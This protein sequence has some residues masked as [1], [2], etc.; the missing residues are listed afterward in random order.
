MKVE[1]GFGAK[2]VQPTA[3]VDVDLNVVFK[4]VADILTERAGLTIDAEKSPNEYTDVD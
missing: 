1:T 3:R 2:N 4:S